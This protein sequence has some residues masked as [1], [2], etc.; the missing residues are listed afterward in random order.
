MIDTV[1]T[2][3][4]YLFNIFFNGNNINIVYFYVN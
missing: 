4:K 1:S 3:V 2:S